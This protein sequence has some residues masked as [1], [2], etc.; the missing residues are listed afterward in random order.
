MS[1]KWLWLIPVLIA[2]LLAVALWR[3]RRPL[4]K[5]ARYVANT[6]TATSLPS[7]A[8]MQ[9]R[10]KTLRIIEVSVLAVLALDAVLIVAR[11]QEQIRKIEYTQSRDIVLCMDT[12]GSM[13]D[14]VIPGLKTLKEVITKYPTDRYALVFFQNVPF[15]A[16]PLTNDTAAMNLILDDFTKQFS[17]QQYNASSSAGFSSAAG[18]GGTDIGAGLAGCIR[19]FDAIAEKRSR[20]IILVSDMEH[21]GKIDPVTVATLLPKYDV[22]LYIVAPQD[23]FAPAQDSPVAKITGASVSTIS[24]TGG[25]PAALATIYTSILNTRQNEVFVQADAP[26]P[27][28]IVATVALAVW[29][30]VLYVR[31]RR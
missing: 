25:F 26:Y 17:S 15:V 19:R 27:Y 10:A 24:D 11:P 4:K 5:P 22:K 29:M 9:S 8:K 2:P 18:G 21:N 13:K 7:F 16:L 20:H 1:I 14:Y 28:W 30:S 12:S 23:D 3:W 6:E 31:W